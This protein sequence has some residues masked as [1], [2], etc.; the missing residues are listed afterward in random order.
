MTTE[1]DDS[2][3]TRPESGVKDRTSAGGIIVRRDADGVVWLALVRGEGAVGSSYIL[4]KG[5]V[6]PG[7]SIEAAARREI[8]EE[9]GFSD[10]TRLEFLG[11]RARLNYE[12]TRWITTHYFLFETRQIDVTPTDPNYAY[13]TDWFPLDGPLPALFWP[14]Q[15]ALIEGERARIRERLKSD[16]T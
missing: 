3:Y 11:T 4:P 9:A 5:G 8:E 6:D 14:E 13:A 12:R 7:E 16:P 10:L 2:W 15:R 1:I